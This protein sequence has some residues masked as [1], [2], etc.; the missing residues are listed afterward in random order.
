MFEWW[1][2]VSDGT[3]ARSTLQDRVAGALQEGLR[4]P[5]AKTGRTCERLSKSTAALWTF[6][7]YE[8]SSPETPTFHFRPFRVSGGFGLARMA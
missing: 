4:S 1:H 7:R 2:R 6:V 8:G 3:L 5:C